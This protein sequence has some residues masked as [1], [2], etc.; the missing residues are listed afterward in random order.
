MDENLVEE[1]GVTL[2]RNWGELIISIEII[3]SNEELG[4]LKDTLR[5]MKI[6]KVMWFDR[7]PI[8]AQKFMG[9]MGIRLFNNLLKEIASAEI[10]IVRWS[11][12]SKA[13]IAHSILTKN[14]Y[15]EKKKIKKKFHH[16]LVVCH[17]PT[18][19]DSLAASISPSK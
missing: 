14:G 9:G 1:E 8:E 12:N 3:G 17:T 5:K 15:I 4:Q 6:R 18:Q 13:T 11:T 10:G 19:F 7:V 2:A 16:P